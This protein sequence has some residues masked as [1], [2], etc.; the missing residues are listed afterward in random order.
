MYFIYVCVLKKV[1]TINDNWNMKLYFLSELVNLGWNKFSI[2]IENCLP[3]V[4]RF[5]CFVGCVA[6]FKS[7]TS[8]QLHL[9]RH[10]QH[11]RMN[12]SV[13]SVQSLAGIHPKK[14][15]CRSKQSGDKRLDCLDLNGFAGNF[16]FISILTFFAKIWLIFNDVFVLRKSFR[17]FKCPHAYI[18]NEFEVEKRRVGI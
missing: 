7:K 17:I 8:L 6:K 2:L 13:Q 16:K 14:S 1:A 4:I 11:Q 3:D 18:W 9:K 5:W 15:E 12:I 10:N